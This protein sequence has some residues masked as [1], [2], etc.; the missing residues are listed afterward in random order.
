MN[1][2]HVVVIGAGLSGLAAAYELS[3][4]GVVDVTLIEAETYIGGRVRSLPVL[5]HKVDFG[6][7]IIYPW[8]KQ[9]HRLMDEV[10]IYEQLESI[11]YKEIFYD[12]DGS[13]ST[14]TPF[15]KLHFPSK[16]TGQLWLKSI[17]KMLQSSDL[18]NPPLD[19]FDRMTIS[20][21]IRSTLG[22]KGHAGIYEDFIDTVSQ[23]Y[24]YG[25][26]TD[27]KAAFI[28]PVIRHT[29]MHGDIRSAF[30]FRHGNEIMAQAMAEKIRN[31]GG[32]IKLNTRMTGIDSH[33]LHTNQGAIDADAFIFAQRVDTDIYTQILP[34]ISPEVAYTHFV[35]A[36]LDFEHA[37][38]IQN[39]D[40]WGAVFYLPNNKTQ[41][42]I[43]SSINLKSLYS[44]KLCGKINVNIVIRDSSITEL[45]PEST[46]ALIKDEVQELFIDYA[47]RG[48]VQLNHW[49]QTMPVSQE[50]FVAKIREIQ[51]KND[52]YFSGD[53]L[54]A[55]SMEVA[56][57]T[58]VNA[59]HMFIEDE[60][61]I[62]P[63]RAIPR[64]ILHAKAKVGLTMRHRSQ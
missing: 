8:Y 22:T 63:E 23:G 12:M 40:D 11:V 55:P 42:Q 26:V 33:T 35:T 58:G 31:N 21:Y 3:K 6:G 27:Y 49:K 13:H 20:E 7:F 37:P 14:Y 39:T 1:K 53:Y 48:I 25:P 4:S 32:T 47:C 2:K 56:L 52:Y 51:G 9:F 29:K 45:T 24:C 60:T 5:N 34:E 59:A 54:G 62:A 57:D 41:T 30:F 43:L 10:D 36:T 19:A 38:E 50:N 15:E 61:G 64:S 46:M 17:R 44:N 28:A 16:E 18:A